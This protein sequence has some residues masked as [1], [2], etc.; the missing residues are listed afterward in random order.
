MR[1]YIYDYINSNLTTGFKLSEELPWVKG[2][3][4]LYLRNMKSIYVDRDQ[5]VQEPL[6][7]TLDGVGFVNETTTVSVYVA[8]D[9]KKLP[10]NYDAMVTT[11]IAAKLDGAITGFT[12][13]ATTVTTEYEGDNLVTQFD[14]NF[15][16]LTN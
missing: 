8:T 1:D 6:F 4:P 3:Q 10:S 16:K 15:Y 14:F 7:D 12:Q 13:K 5:T 9:A 2:N 11:L